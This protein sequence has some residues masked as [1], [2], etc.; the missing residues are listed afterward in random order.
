MAQKKKKKKEIQI[1][2]HEG[3][4]VRV[5]SWIYHESNIERACKSHLQE[6]R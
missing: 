6:L 3:E 1:H 5:Q 4:R 2:I